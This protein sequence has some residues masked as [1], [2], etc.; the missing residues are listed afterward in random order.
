M[1]FICVYIKP[2]YI[3]GSFL[4]LTATVDILGLNVDLIKVVLIGKTTTYG[5]A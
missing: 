4:S 5:L 3:Y 1:I 2:F